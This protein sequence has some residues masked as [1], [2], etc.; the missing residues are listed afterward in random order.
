MTTN[1]LQFINAIRKTDKYIEMIYM[2]G[3]CYQFFLLLKT[4]FPECEPYITN[5]KNHVITKYNGKYYDITG[6]VSGNWYTPMTDSEIDMASA[7]SFHRTKVI[8]IGECPF[9]GEPIVV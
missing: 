8:Q 3:A 2:N 5:E 4:Y 1:I 9:C 6:Q 7:W